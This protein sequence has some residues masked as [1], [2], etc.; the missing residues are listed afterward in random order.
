MKK[1]NKEWHR[2]TK[3]LK[4]KKLCESVGHS[5]ATICI[6]GVRE[7]QYRNA[8]GQVTGDR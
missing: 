1:T 7:Y 6:S 8:W 2:A 3:P 5:C 4:K